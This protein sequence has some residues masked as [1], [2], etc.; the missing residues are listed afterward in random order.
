MPA[1]WDIRAPALK[2][3]T[4]LSLL[5]SLTTMQT[6]FAPPKATHDTN[7]P[8]YALVYPSADETSGQSS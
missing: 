4:T 3:V 6:T 8:G 7:Y 2:R 1:V 5:S